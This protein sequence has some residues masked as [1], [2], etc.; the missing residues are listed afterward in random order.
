[1]PTHFQE[2]KWSI[3]EL[4]LH[5]LP[6]PSKNPIPNSHPPIPLR[7]AHIRPPHILDRHTPRI[8][9]STI[10]TLEPFQVPQRILTDGI[11]HNIPH[12][13]RIRAIALHPEIRLV[14]VEHLRGVR[15]DGVAGRHL[16]VQGVQTGRVGGCEGGEV[17][18]E[19]E[20]GD[21]GEGADC[22]GHEGGEVGGGG[23]EE[24]AEDLVGW[25][26]GWWWW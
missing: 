5:L 23:S 19:G 1:M 11:L 22:G 17:G 21:V 24:V 7:P 26:V 12:D 2:P 14:D 18:E 20:D 10:T 4:Y 9:I 6:T 25:L 3:K 13:R 8:L 16:H 15:G